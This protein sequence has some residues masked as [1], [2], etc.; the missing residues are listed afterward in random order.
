MTGH[1]L[2]IF[3]IGLAAATGII[4]R[5]KV[6]RDSSLASRLPDLL[7]SFYLIAQGAISIFGPAKWA[8]LVD[9][10][11]PSLILLL[12]P[13]VISVTISKSERKAGHASGTLWLSIGIAIALYCAF[14]YSTKNLTNSYILSASLFAVIFLTIAMFSFQGIHRLLLGLAVVTWVIHL[15]EL[16]RM[17]NL[18]VGVFMGAIIF[19]SLIQAGQGMF[20]NSLRFGLGDFFRAVPSPFIILDLSGKI[21]FSNPE[22]QRLSGYDNT[23]LLQREAIDLF[24]IPSDWRFKLCSSDK[25]RKVRC[26][27]IDKKGEKI[28]VL[29]WLNDIQNSRNEPGNILCLIQE[30]KERELLENRLK[31]DSVRFAGLYETSMALSSSL[32]MHDVLKAIS[33][34]A[35]NLTQA[36][37]CTIFSLDH[38]RQ[39]IRPIYSSEEA[40]NAEVMNFEL[41]VGQG[42]TGM[43]VRDGKPRVQNF[44]DDIKLAKHV[45]GTTDEAESL[46]SVPL[47]AKDVVIGALT[48]YKNGPRRFEE[49]DAKVLTVFASQA[50]AIIETSRLYM[51]LKA[52]E[53]LYR[54]SVDMAGDAIFF[55]DPE[56]GKITDSNEMAHKLFKYSRSEFASMHIWEAH[57]EPQ[58]PIAKRL[59]QETKKIGWGKLGEIN[60]LTKDGQLIP[61]SVN[62]SIIFTGELTSIQWIVRDISE[63]KHALERKSLIL[64]I[65]ERLNEPVLITSSEG[66]AIYFNDAFCDYF[67]TDGEQLSMAEVLTIGLLNPNLEPLKGCWEKLQTDSFLIAEPICPRLYESPTKLLSILSCRENM[68]KPDCYVWFFQSEAGQSCPRSFTEIEAEK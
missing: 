50:S 57:P 23:V 8:E 1:E 21:V 12:L 34:A 52:S 54:F 49:D 29:L 7:I 15:G 13:A 67:K 33:R 46:L 27:L 11:L 36:D 64:H 65:F 31:T 4:M 43:V 6:S 58:M 19:A 38:A 30:E 2:L 3:L 44:D 60:Y 5:V 55:V 22:F 39:V 35:E 68:G 17:A 62:V 61:A 26:R 14:I 42:L 32:E 56:T 45:P 37:S 10:K 63:Y 51:K 47:V 18:G 28:P 48:L 20:L 41:P 66:K 53:K 16:P 9:G 25:F 59:W 40:F 24:D